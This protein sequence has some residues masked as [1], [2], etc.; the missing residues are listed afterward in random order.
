MTSLSINALNNTLKNNPIIHYRNPKSGHCHK[1]ELFMSLLG[2]CYQNHNLDMV[3][4]AHKSADFITKNPF[5]QVPVIVDGEHT[6]S[7]SNAIIVYLADTYGSDYPWVGTTAIEKANVQRWLSVAAGELAK[8]PAALRLEYVF[9]ANIDVPTALATTKILLPV[10][11]DTL[12][13]P[14][15]RIESST[16]AYLATNR[17]TLADIAMY[18]YIAHA[19]EGG[20]SLQPYPAIQAWINRIESLDNFIPMANSA[21]AD[22]RL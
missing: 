16:K 4:G 15:S 5:G 11:E 18:S 6:V 20:V 8:G 14:K 9:A 22:Y 2:I 13:G 3:N 19:P 17:L 12:L 10:M 21:T 7:D 1:V